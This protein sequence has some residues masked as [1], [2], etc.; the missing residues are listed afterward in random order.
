MAKKTKPALIGAFVIGAV[1]LVVLAVV[2]WGSR[3]LFERKYEYI[4]YF[5]GS[6]DGL[7][8]GAPI[9]YRGVEVGVVKDI[10]VRYRQ[11]TDDSRIPVVG[12]VWA[13]RLRELGGRE[14]NVELLRELVAKGLRARLASASIVTGVMYV[15]LEYAPDSPASYAEIPGPGAIPEIPTLPT[16]L[17]EVTQALSNL[18][19]SLSTTDFKGTA[20]SVSEAMNGVNQAVTSSDLKAAIEQLPRVLSGAR[21]LTRTLK[22]DADKTGGVVDDMQGAI[23]ALVETLDSTRGAISP[24]APLSVNLGVTLVD[25]DKAAVA[26]RELA[27]FLRRNPHAIVAGTKPR[28]TVP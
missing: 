12:E 9:K 7:T 13:K 5:P 28:E 16:K 27:D 20:D 21:A 22:A 6:V 11:S 8:R 14:P 17:D 3:S 4:C 1:A 25:V 26:V 24:H 18:L 2:I 19:S 10:K 23:G 15:S